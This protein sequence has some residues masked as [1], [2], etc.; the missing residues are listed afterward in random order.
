MSDVIFDLDGLRLVTEWNGCQTRVRLA[1]YVRWMLMRLAALGHRLSICSTTSIE[2]TCQ[3]LE[4]FGIDD[5][6]QSI[7]CAGDERA[8]VMFLREKAIGGDLCAYVGNRACDFAFVREAGIVSIG[9]AYGYNDQESCTA[10]D[11]TADSARQVVDRVCQ[12]AVYHALYS[13][14]IRDGDRRQIGINGVDTSGKTTFS[15]GLAR[16]LASRRIPCVVVHADD[17][18]FPSDV[19]NQGMDPAESYY[20]N[21]FDYERLVREVLAPMKADGMLRRDVIC[22]NL[23]TDRYEKTLRLDIGPETVVLIEGV[24]LFREPVDSYL[25][26]RIFVRIPFSVVLRRASVRDVPT[27]GMNYLD[28]YRVRF[29]PAERRYL[30]EYNP[31]IRSD[32]VVD[33]RNYNRPRLLRLAGGSSQ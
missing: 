16:Y 30:Q 15:E 18:H 12:T 29:I 22:L 24:L 23:H 19:R 1:P 10:A 7:H 26:A 14:L 25:D 31:E 9:I 2:H 6:F 4:T 32:A 5:C 21:A 11:Y 3:F 13:A 20:R 17:F 27:H 28:R 33:N 8:K